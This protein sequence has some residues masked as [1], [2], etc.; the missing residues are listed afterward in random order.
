[1]SR[2]EEHILSLLKA[3]VRE[4]MPPGVRVFLYGSR[5]RGDYHRDSDW[6]L[7][8]LVN[9]PRAEMKD[10][11][12]LSYPLT[13]IG[14]ENGAAV[15]PVVYGREEWSHPASLL[16]RKSVEQDAIELT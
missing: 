13:E 5:A 2:K 1:M 4:V 9:K 12:N 10:F 15:I 11:D 8:I 6:D 3:K 16:F 14:W 7:L